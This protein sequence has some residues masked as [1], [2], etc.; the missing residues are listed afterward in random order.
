ML[1][2]ISALLLIMGLTTASIVGKAHAQDLRNILFQEGVLIG[3]SLVCLPEQY[4]EQA[5]K[6]VM[7]KYTNWH[8]QNN[9]KEATQMAAPALVDGFTSGIETQREWGLQGCEEILEHFDRLSQVIGY[10][11]PRTPPGKSILQPY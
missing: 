6:E 5:S 11:R 4:Q 1:K 3:R 2:T 8:I 7:T 9:G 10:Q